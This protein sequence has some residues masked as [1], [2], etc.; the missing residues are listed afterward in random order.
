M[1]E[2]RRGTQEGTPTNHSTKVGIF[3]Q[4]AKEKPENYEG[5]STNVEILEKEGKDLD[6][7]ADSA[8][9]S[10]PALQLDAKGNI[11]NCAENLRIIAEHDPKL[12]AIHYDL[13]QGRFVVSEDNEFKGANGHSLDDD[14]LAEISA[15]IEIEYG[16]KVSVAKLDEK[17]MYIIRKKRGFHPIKDFILKEQWDGKHRLDA[18]LVEY[19]GAEDTALN[20]AMTRKWMVAAV[21]RIFEPGIKFDYVLTLA[22]K[23]RIGKSTFFCTIANKVWFSDALSF[24]LDITRQR[25]AVQGNWIV[26]IAELSG[27]RKADMEAAKAFITNTADEWRKAFGRLKSK[28]PRQCVLG[29]TT[30]EEHFL[31]STTGDRRFWVVDVTAKRPVSVWRPELEAEVPQI[32]AEAYT[33]YVAGEK[34]YL[35]EELEADA[36]IVQA[37]HNEFENSPIIGALAEWLETTSREYTCVAEVICEFPGS[38]HIPISKRGDS[39]YIG[40][41]LDR[42]QGWKRLEKTMRFAKYGVQRGWKKL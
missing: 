12:K 21:A 25:E 9:A 41:L 6:A 22:G 36:A 1:E 34:L 20:R 24:S 11:K 26:E 39:R 16:I 31:R 35:S 23:E 30:N 7:L 32:W 14:S 10:M 5:F 37:K 3:S 29:G 2:K 4:I 19:L 38:Y 18:L 8:Q 17:L 27:L 40:K 42:V 33:Y 28:I 13:F 15:Y